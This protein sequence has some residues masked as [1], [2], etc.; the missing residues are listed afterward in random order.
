MQLKEFLQHLNE[1]VK[2]HPD[3]IN[4]DVVYSSDEEGNNFKK[5][6]YA[7]QLGL[8]DGETFGNSKDEKQNNSICIN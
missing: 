4:F 6:F 8:F 5:V 1:L 2:K 7:P 3:A